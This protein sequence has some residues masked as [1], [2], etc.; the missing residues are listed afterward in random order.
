MTRRFPGLLVVGAESPPFRA[1][2]REEDATLVERVNAAR[3]DIV[4][5]GLGSPK[6]EL[7]AAEHQERLTT[8]LILPVGA[9]FDFHSGR[10][11]RAPRWMQRVGLE[12]LFRLARDPRRLTRRYL[13]TNSRFVVLLLREE[14]TLLGRRF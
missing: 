2:S 11:R 8:G 1:L 12:W 6:Q 3:P 10:A 4:W 14:L 9:A 5:V 7:W 13:V